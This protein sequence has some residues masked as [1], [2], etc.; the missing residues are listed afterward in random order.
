MRKRKTGRKFHRTTDQRKAF[1]RH[2]VNALILKDKIKTTEP[3]AKEIRSLAEKS[4]TTAKKNNV[5]AHRLL[6]AKFPEFV[7]KKL[8][9]DLAK[10]YQNRQ[11][12]Y[13][14]VIKSGRRLGD[15]A[16]TAIIELI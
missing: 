1:L 8:I 12:G 3:R 13:T 10:K 16:K 9:N 4:I 11:G 14:R 15:A 6:R 5:T 7:V 2:L